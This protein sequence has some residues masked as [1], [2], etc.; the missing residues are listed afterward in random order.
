[1]PVLLLTSHLQSHSQTHREI[2]YLCFYI[3]QTINA[4]LTSNPKEN[5][6]KCIC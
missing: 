6:L 1:M 2:I 4:R 5:M 3:K